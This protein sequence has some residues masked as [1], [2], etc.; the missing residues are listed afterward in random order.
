MIRLIAEI[1]IDSPDA[2]YPTFKL[3]MDSLRDQTGRPLSRV[4]DPGEQYVN[5]DP[6]INGLALD[7]SGW[8][9]PVER[10]RRQPSGPDSDRDA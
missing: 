4:V 10:W 5:P 8:T 3:P 6:E 2:F 7:L 9:E 1:R